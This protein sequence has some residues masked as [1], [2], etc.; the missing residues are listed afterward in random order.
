MDVVDTDPDGWRCR[1]SAW[2]LIAQNEKVST[3]CSDLSFRWS[4][5]ATE[6]QSLWDDMYSPEAPVRLRMLLERDA[7]ISKSGNAL[8]NRERLL[9][10][11][12]EH[13]VRHHTAPATA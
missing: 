6:Y 2:S 3:D 10:K 11:W 8:P 1:L 13:V 5:L 9:Q 12:E 7:E 4:K